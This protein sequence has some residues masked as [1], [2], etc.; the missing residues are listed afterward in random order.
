MIGRR[1]FLGAIAAAVA[2]AQL[3]P[4]RLLWV[5]GK[6]LISVPR[7]TAPAGFRIGDTIM[8]RKPTLFI[9]RQGLTFEPKGIPPTEF[10]P[11]TITGTHMDLPKL[12]AAGLVVN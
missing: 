10:E 2:G 1:G 7:F 12:H 5:P 6:K 4:E 9:V 8:I 3:D 11:Y